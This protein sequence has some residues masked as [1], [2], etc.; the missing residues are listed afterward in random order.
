MSNDLAHRMFRSQW[1][2]RAPL[3]IRLLLLCS[4]SSHREVSPSHPLLVTFF[5]LS[6][7]S[8]SPNGPASAR[9]TFRWMWPDPP[10]DPFNPSVRLHVSD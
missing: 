10:C 1:L 6:P 8:S 7:V 2:A 4:H 5:I 9:V 3:A